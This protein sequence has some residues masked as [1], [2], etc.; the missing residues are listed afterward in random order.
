MVEEHYFLGGSIHY[1]RFS[2]G[3]WSDILAKVRSDG[4]NH[5][6][7]YKNIHFTLTIIIFGLIWSIKYLFVCILEHP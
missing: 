5:V 1:S 4:S 3:Q 6:Q 2:P 7:V